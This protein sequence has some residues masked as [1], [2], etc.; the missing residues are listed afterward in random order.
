MKGLAIA[1]RARV[2]LWLAGLILVLA[3][4]I[5]GYST[6]RLLLAQHDNRLI[7]SLG[8]GHDLATSASDPAQLL[9]ARLHF[10]LLRDRLDEAQPLLNQIVRDGDARQSA[11]ALYAMANARLRVAFA[12]LEKGRIDP[13]IPLVRLAKEGYRR[14]L[15]LDP[16]FWD[17]KYNLDIAMRLVRDFPQIE[18]SGEELPPEAA[19]KLWTELPGLPKGLP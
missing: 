18:Q 4:G 3:L 17:A 16:E 19:K 6:V 8:Q 10:L 13:A 5:A 9:Y 11:V 14:A 1:T 12:Q 2:S 7:L 15:G